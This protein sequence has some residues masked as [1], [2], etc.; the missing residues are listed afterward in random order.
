[1][2]TGVASNTSLQLRCSTP[3]N[4]TPRFAAALSGSL[5]ADRNCA[6]RVAKGSRR[7]S[8]ADKNARLGN[9]QRHRAFPALRSAGTNRQPL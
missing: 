5:T 4:R 9:F 8:Q 3:A 6:T 2:L 1:M 7:A